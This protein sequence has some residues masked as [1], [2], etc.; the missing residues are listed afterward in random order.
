M[1]RKVHPKLRKPASAEEIATFEAKTGHELPLS[2]KEFLGIANG[3]EGAD[4]YDWAIAGVTPVS[5]GESFDDVKS[6]HL[7]VYRDKDPDHPVIADLEESWVVGSD[8]DYQVVYW[9][10]D[11]IDDPEPKI[12]RV[13]LDTEYDHYPLFENFTQFLAFIVEIYDDLL[14]FQNEPLEEG[15]AEE[16]NLLR[17]LAALLEQAGGPSSGGGSGGATGGG[18]VAAEDEGAGAGAGALAAALAG[19]PEPEP[20]PMDP[21]MQLAHKLCHLALQKLIDADL[22]ELVQAPGCRENLED[23]MLRKLLR[24]KSPEETAESWIYALSKAREVEE[25][26]GTDEELTSVMAEAFEEVAAEKEE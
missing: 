11:T 9:D 10:P 25:L 26:Y 16:E 17:E 4:Q 6:G 21:E 24:S 15:L 13:G 1:G 14:S 23:Y 5:S 22:V 7:Y 18:G 8:F 3:M 12:R 19:P 2:Y 20:P